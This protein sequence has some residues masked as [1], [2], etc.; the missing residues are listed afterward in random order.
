VVHAPEWGAL[1]APLALAS[2]VPVVTRLDT[3]SFWVRELNGR[4]RPTRVEWLVERAE[5]SQARASRLVLPAS[6]AVAELVRPRWCLPERRLRLLPYPVD[7][8]RLRAA[9][10]RSWPAAARPG[11]IVYIGRLETRKSLDV[12]APLLIDALTRTDTHVTVVGAVAAGG[13]EPAAVALRQAL[14]RF[15]ERVTFLGR[16]WHGAAMAVVAA[17]DLVV[18]PSVWEN[19]PLVVMEAMTLGR[20]VVA[21]A[22]GG[23]SELVAEGSTGFLVRGRRPADWS[24]ATL[25]LLADAGRRAAVGRRASAAAAA[26]DVDAVAR[27]ALRRGRGVTFAAGRDAQQVVPVAVARTVRRTVRVV[28]VDQRVMPGHAGP[29]GQPGNRVILPIEPEHRAA[30]TAAESRDERSREACRAPLDTE[31]VSPERPRDGNGGLP[32]TQR[33]LREPP[34]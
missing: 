9:A 21:A 28:V 24:A 27:R 33:Q 22:V 32:F 34:I 19:S 7:G 30:A 18:V 6:A 11:G 13:H 12:L 20:T 8:A 4:P 31:A 1:A 10:A 5:A 25:P 14:A 29:L 16:L 26:W 3:P 17:A 15:G 23:I 2:R